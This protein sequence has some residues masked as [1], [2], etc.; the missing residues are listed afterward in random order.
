MGKSTNVM[1]TVIMYMY[2]PVV[3]IQ[4]TLIMDQNYTQSVFNYLVRSYEILFVSTVKLRDSLSMNTCTCGYVYM[5]MWV[6]VHACT[7]QD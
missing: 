4:S 1:Y 3:K 2:I 6:C 7:S 5:Y